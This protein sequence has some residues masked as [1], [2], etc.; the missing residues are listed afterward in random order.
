MK[1]KEIS[2]NIMRKPDE[3]IMIATDAVG[4]ELFQKVGLRPERELERL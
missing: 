2:V 3:E 1:C 4:G